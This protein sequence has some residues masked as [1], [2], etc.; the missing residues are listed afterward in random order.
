MCRVE[1]NLRHFF[2]SSFSKVVLNAVFVLGIFS[3][4]PT[5]DDIHVQM[6]SLFARATDLSPQIRVVHYFSSLEVGSLANIRPL[7]HVTCTAAPFTV[8]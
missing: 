8:L 4:Y 1:Y 5:A 3:E 6:R 2:V 7:G